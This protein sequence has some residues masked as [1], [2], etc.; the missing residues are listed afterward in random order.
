MASERLPYYLKFSENL[1]YMSGI[2]KIETW[3]KHTFCQ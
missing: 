2:G 3:F 1:R